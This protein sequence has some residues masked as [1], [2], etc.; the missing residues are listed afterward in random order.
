MGMKKLSEILKLSVSL[1]KTCAR[2]AEK[3]VE[4]DDGNF[5][6]QLKGYAV[7][8]TDAVRTVCKLSDREELISGLELARKQ[9]YGINNW[10][11]IVFC[12]GFITKDR[13]SKADKKCNDIQVK[14]IDSIR[15][16]KANGTLK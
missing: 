12:A 5:L 6:G 10:L 15:L 16:L 1:E 8:L 7:G 4:G 11:Q 3:I 13:F 9:A 2:F 14:L